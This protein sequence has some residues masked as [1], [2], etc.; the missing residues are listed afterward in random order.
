MAA[1][2]ELLGR[3]PPQVERV[4]GTG[5]LRGRQVGPGRHPAAAGVG[6][7]R[8]QPGQQL[9]A[10]R[11]LPRADVEAD[12][13]QARRPVEGELRCRLVGGAAGVAGRSHSGARRHEVLD[14][15]RRARGPRFLPRLGQAE[16][17]VRAP[18]FR[19]Q[20]DGSL[21][22]AVVEGLEG[23]PALERAGAHPVAGAQG[24][25]RRGVA[26]CELGRPRGDL[27]IDRLARHRD[28]LEKPPRFG[29]KAGGPGFE[30][31]VEAQR[32]DASIAGR[33]LMA[34]E[35]VDEEGAAAGLARDLRRALQG[36][37]TLLTDHRQ[38]ELLRLVRR[39]LGEL[40]GPAPILLL[41]AVGD[42]GPEERRAPRL[43]LAEA[44]QQQHRRRVGRPRD[45]AHQGGAVHVPPL[46][47]V[48]EQGD[49]R[50]VGEPA[51]ELPQGGERAPPQL[52][53][54]RHLGLAAPPGSGLA[55]APEDREQPRERR[56]V[57]RHE[58]RSLERCH[59]AEV[60]AELVDQ[61]VE[62]LVG[63]VLALVAAALE[64]QRARVLLPHAVEKAARQ[65]GLAHP[66]GAA[67]EDRRRAA[68]ADPIEGLVEHRQLPAAA[69][70]AR[71]RARRRRGDRDLQLPVE[72]AGD[73]GA[74]GPCRGI[75]L[76]ELVAQLVEVGRRAG[77]QVA[78]AGH[79]RRLAVEQDLRVRA[80]EKVRAGQGFVEHHADAVPVA[81]RTDLAAHRLLGRHVGRRADDL[82]RPG[83]VV[84]SEV[85]DEAEVEDDHP[86]VAGHQHV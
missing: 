43:L 61:A 62:R 79:G 48:D 25:H 35:L 58:P 51:Q 69:D 28:H 73:L 78:H 50:A 77:H 41:L 49:R 32:L 15:G 46:Q 7:G 85:G 1:D 20:R 3:P 71:S 14:Q 37:S 2:Q 42:E 57:A 55:Q 16:V 45:L 70:E 12:L 29:G 59:P 72:A 64:H 11:C 40:D 83:Q 82:H 10:L 34:R 84:P 18:G 4:L 30:H 13:V 17:T 66:R 22:D 54:I 80:A 21:A 39:Q 26:G 38:R 31:R 65:G 68:G 24:I 67:D 44:D 53:R 81:R 47:V 23:V 75:E 33:G 6:Q 52:Q 19:N 8:R 5:R 63:H 60:A 56:L 27:E 86:A 74:V 9:P 76:Q 36:V